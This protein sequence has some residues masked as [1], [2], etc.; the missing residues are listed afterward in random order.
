MP[1]PISVNTYGVITGN[2]TSY[3][4][5]HTTKGLNRGLLAHAATAG[6]SA[7]NVKWD[8]TTLI[9]V[10]GKLDGLALGMVNAIYKDPNP[11]LL[12][13]GD[14]TATMQ[15]GNISGLMAL[16]FNG[17]DI[18]G[19]TE[20][21][22]GNST[23]GTQLNVGN[24]SVTSGA[25]LAAGLFTFSADPG[26]WTTASGVT[27][28]MSHYMGA[29]GGWMGLSYQ[30]PHNPPGSLPSSN[31][32]GEAELCN[33]VAVVVKPQNGPNYETSYTD[34]TS[35]DFEALALDEA[36]PF[37][38]VGLEMETGSYTVISSGC[39]VLQINTQRNWARIQEQIQA[40]TASILLD[41]HDG[42]WSPDNAAGPYAGE[43]KLKQNI[44]IWMTHQGSHYDLFT[45]KTTGYTTNPEIGQ[46]KLSLNA[47]DRF[48]D[49]RARQLS[50][51]V[52]TG[53]NMGSLMSAVLSHGGFTAAQQSL[54][55]MGDTVEFA[56]FTE[57]T[58]G[59][60]LG[61]IVNYGDARIWIAPDGTF[62]AHDRNTN[63][64]ATA[65]QTYSDADGLK[66]MGYNLN[67]ERLK[68]V[69]RVSATPRVTRSDAGSVS[70]LQG[71]VFVEASGF[72][73]V[74]LRFV[75][76]DDPNQQATPASSIT[77][78]GTPV[79]TSGQSGTGSDL[80]STL[81]Y[82]I[83][84]FA[85]KAVVTL[86]NGTSGAGYLSAF[87]LQGYSHQ[88]RPGVVFESVGSASR[89]L[90]GTRETALENPLIT[91]P[92]HAEGLAGYLIDQDEEPF[93]NVNFTITNSTPDIYQRDLG[94]VVALTETHTGVNS[95]YEISGIGH[96]ITLESGRQHMVTMDLKRLELK[97]YF[98]LGDATKG[99]LDGSNK[100]GF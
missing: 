10:E 19:L 35:H 95:L 4:L 69:A 98:V 8:T 33:V 11:A 81:S 60:A 47:L 100:L 17:A 65:V 43:L 96:S 70:W 76:T 40:G 24:T 58:F 6:N 55:T 31:T 49:L 41:N 26:G 52:L 22:S 56:A 21:S 46:R 86:F 83:G 18:V 44:R 57:A 78:L 13:D 97:D 74:E 20:A 67:L 1:I 30:G 84:A 5:Q 92:N 68:N 64:A 14:L 36:V 34:V 62:R 15:N 61:Q 39:Q 50:M 23:L 32:W 38:R 79:F 51:P 42:R 37:Y 93:A 80:F 3:T 82:S 66:G 54:E 72:N 99:K 59:E 90:Y 2:A 25:W 77:V 75:D 89:D 73:T 7:L 45:G 53:I 27:Q 94:Q 16:S 63:N 29:G 91:N 28:V 87:V 9:H 88:L 85:T 71:N 12:T 48:E